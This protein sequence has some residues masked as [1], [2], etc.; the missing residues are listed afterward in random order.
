M[1][2][3]IIKWASLP[4]LLVASLFSR[5]AGNY[6]LLVDVAICL[7]AVV[8]VQRAIHSR[9]YFWAAGLVGIA[10]VFSPVALAVKIFLLMGVTFIAMSVTLGAAFRTKLRWLRIPKELERMHPCHSEY[11]SP[12]I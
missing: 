5:Y 8:F 2:T 11:T 10:I 9:E 1:T 12:V 6:E 7:G 4:V 3:K